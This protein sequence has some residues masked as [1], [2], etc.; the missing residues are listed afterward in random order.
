MPT[1]LV[2][3]AVGLVSIFVLFFFKILFLIRIFSLLCFSL[4]GLH[5]LHSNWILH[6]DVKPDNVLMTAQDDQR[7]PGCVKIG[8]FVS[9]A[10]LSSSIVLFIQN[11]LALERV[12]CW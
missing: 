10:V 2:P 4:R 3:R 6:R 8:V 7:E 9:P 1:I 5:F 12:F 11:L